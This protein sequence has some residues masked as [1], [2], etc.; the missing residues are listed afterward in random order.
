M[1][2]ARRGEVRADAAIKSAIQR[3]GKRIAIGVLRSTIGGDL[4]RFQFDV[5]LV[6]AV[7]QERARRPMS[8]EAAREKGKIGEKTD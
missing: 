6:K 4:K 2:P 7:E 1:N 3:N 8:I 5:R